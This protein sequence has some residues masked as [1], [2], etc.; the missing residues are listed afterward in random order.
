MKSSVSDKTLKELS[1]DSY[2]N[3]N[4]DVVVKIGD[5]NEVWKRVDIDNKLLHNPKNSFDATVYKNE[6]TK[7]IVI[8]YRGSQ[9]GPDFYDADAFDVVGGRLRKN[10]ESLDNMNALD[11]SLLPLT[12]Q[13]NFAAAKERAKK[14]VEE[15]QFTNADDLTQ[16]IKKY[17][18]D[19]KNGLDGYQLTLTGHSLGGGLSEYSGVM[20]DVAAVSFEAPNVIDLLPKDKK[21]KSI[22][23]RI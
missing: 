9:E 6:E 21:R 22:K 23:R 14:I 20:N 13:F 15:S 10:I 11:T 17:M 18:A 16:E 12:E 7:Q 3:S 1:D 4:E 8:A 2:L 5:H 19:P